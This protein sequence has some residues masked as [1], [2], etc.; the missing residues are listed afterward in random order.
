MK[1]LCLIDSLGQGGAEHQIIC[2]TNL[3]KQA[4]YDVELASYYR[5]N[6]YLSQINQ[7]DIKWSMIPCVGE[8]RF[9]KIKRIRDFIK[10]NEYTHLITYKDG[11]SQIGC[12]LKIGGL[13]ISLIVSERNTSQSLNFSNKLKF[14]LYRWADY[15][16]P[17]S[18]SQKSFICKHFPNLERKTIA[19]TN[20]VD[21]EVYEPKGKTYANSKTPVAILV[22][23]RISRQKNV[24]GFMKA[25][26]LIREKGTEIQVNWFGNVDTNETD[27]G[28]EVFEYYRSSELKSCLTFHSATIDIVSEYHKCD[29]FCLPSLFEGCP[30]VIYEAMSSGAPIL[31]S[32]V[33][34]NPQIVKD[35]IN[36]YLFNPL[37]PANMADVIIRFCGLD[38]DKKKQM[39]QKSIEIA[40]EMFSSSA[41][42][43]K[44]ISLL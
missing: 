3:L 8:K 1:I 44:Y 16:I 43:S 18:F 41:F 11:A 15:V 20:Y 29:V 17:N 38:A 13:K 12:L 34:D 24:F 14:F 40:D 7:Y 25:I 33:C 21:R 42:I 4:G 6:F 31:C 27:Y 5:E 30:N 22:A 2:L 26:E 32:N 9:V 10:N 37:N 36:G 19:I 28:R 39:S 35:G 23:G